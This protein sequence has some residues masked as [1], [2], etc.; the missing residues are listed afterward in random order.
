MSFRIPGEISEYW[1]TEDIRR[2]LGCL[3]EAGWLHSGEQPESLEI[4]YSEKGRAGMRRLSSFVENHLPKPFRLIPETRQSA[5][6]SEQVSAIFE[7]VCMGPLRIAPELFSFSF[8][9]R[10]TNAFIALVIAFALENQ[11]GGSGS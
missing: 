9:T 1:N 4:C 11:R 7:K 5:D 6:Y 10:E 3:G 2:V 8:S